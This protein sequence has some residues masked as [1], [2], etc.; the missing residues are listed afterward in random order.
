MGSISALGWGLIAPDVPPAVLS[1][2]LLMCSQADT[3]NE[4]GVPRE[5][6]EI[7][8]R[9][10]ES[11]VKRDLRELRKLGLIVRGDQRKVAYLPRNQRPVVYRLCL[12]R[13]DPI[14][15]LYFSGI[16]GDL[17]RYRDIHRG[18][19]NDPPVENGGVT[20]D[21]PGGS[22]TTPRGGHP[23]PL[24]GVTSD[25]PRGGRGGSSSL[26]GEDQ[27]PAGLAAGDGRTAVDNSTKATAPAREFAASLPGVAGTSG[28]RITWLAARLAPALERW[29]AEALRREITGH[30]EDA[31]DPIAVY[32][33]RAGQLGDPP[34]VDEHPSAPTTSGVHKCPDCGLRKRAPGLC[35]ECRADREHRSGAPASTLADEHASSGVSG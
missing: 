12:E 21:P 29:G 22:P 7:A 24:G 28:R 16:P 1:T 10:S 32:A 19:T 26:S 8:T 30:I 33:H 5:W 13:I 14:R 20:S 35:R 3:D 9:K 18:V 27:K 34:V 6:L 11:Q 31:R 15:A 17:E 25:P 4:V 2:L 23:R